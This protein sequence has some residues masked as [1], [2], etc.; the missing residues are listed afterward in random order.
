MSTISV[1]IVT[2][3][4]AA[5]L[6]VCLRALLAQRGIDFAVRVW[7]NASSDNSVSIARAHGV[8]VTESGENLGYAAAHNRLIDATQSE[9][10]LTLNPDARLLPGFL[11]EMMARLDGG[12]RIGSAAG[13]LLR[14][15]RIDGDP[16]CIDSTGLIMRRTRRQ[17]LANE[18]QPINL[19]KQFT[20]DGFAREIFGVDGACAFYRRAMLDDIRVNGEV[21]D[22]DF[23]MHKED[24][25]VAWR[26]RLRGW[27]C[28]YVPDALAHHIRAF[29]PGQRAGVSPTM[30]YLGTRNRY[31]LLIKNEIAAGFRED[32]AYIAAYDAGI[33][34]YLIGHEPRSLPA[35]RDA[36]RMR[37]KMLAKR[38]LIQ[39]A[40]RV[41]W[42]DLRRWFR[43]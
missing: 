43:G 5:T 12:A 24:I 1:H 25:D 28:V 31:A 42:D 30:R 39:A 10:V 9:Y 15:E 17:G 11:H 16:I 36:W 32:L 33:A 19:I 22:E 13:S 37:P 4:S 40:R 38:Q 34:A 29:R 26:A 23:F 41:E 35:L 20:R 3:N 7:D 21:F 18:G 27:A 6:D 2:Y 14:V 8:M